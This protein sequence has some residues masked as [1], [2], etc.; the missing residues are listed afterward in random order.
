M[1]LYSTCVA[2]DMVMQVV[3]EDQTRHPCCGDEPVGYLENLQRKYVQAAMNDA[4]DE[5]NQ[6][7]EAIEAYDNAPARLREAALVYARDYGWPVFPCKP[8]DKVPATR[9]GFHDATT[10]TAQIGRWW[11][12][13]PRYNIGL[14]T[15]H[16][17]DVLDIDV[18]TG[19]FNWVHLRDSGKM[20]DVHGWVTTPSSGFHVY[21][22][23]TG[24]GN[25]TAAAPGVD[26]R[27]NGGYVVAPPSVRTDLGDRRYSW[28]IYPSPAIKKV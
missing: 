3:R 13:N 12:D 20:P 25:T 28:S 5:A 16:S 26:F 2:C 17:F 18:P 9:H 1:K 7:A 23:P 19:T 14:A 24:V 11:R 6:L 8:G 22:I 4:Y 10:D 15:G 27:G 21:L